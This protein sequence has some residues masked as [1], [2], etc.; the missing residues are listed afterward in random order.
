MFADFI[1]VAQ[2]RQMIDYDG[3]LNQIS[4]L[5]NAPKLYRYDLHSNC[6]IVCSMFNSFLFC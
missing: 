5:M 1:E 2:H 6:V 3:Y 4:K